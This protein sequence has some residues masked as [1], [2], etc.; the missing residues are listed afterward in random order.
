MGTTVQCMSTHRP[1]QTQTSKSLGGIPHKPY[2]QVTEIKKRHTSSLQEETE[3]LSV[4][5]PVV[6]LCVEEPGHELWASVGVWLP[7]D[8]KDERDSLQE[9]TQVTDI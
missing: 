6:E 7:L 5:N 3:L 4:D 2:P 8:E 1:T 9:G